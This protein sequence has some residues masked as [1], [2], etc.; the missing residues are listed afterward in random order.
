[1]NQKIASLVGILLVIVG[2]ILGCFSFPAAE[3]ISF[4][5]AMFGAGVIC[6]ALWKN[7]KKETPTWLAI[8]SMILIGIGAFMVGFLGLLELDVFKEVIGYVIS[9]I[10]ILIGIFLPTV[11]KIKKDT[12]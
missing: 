9:I 6:V 1:M 8:V 3:I 11:Q 7:R 10:M 4:A 12:K 5:V 2:V